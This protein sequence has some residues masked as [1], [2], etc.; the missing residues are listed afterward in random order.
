MTQHWKPSRLALA[1]PRSA[2]W[3]LHLEGEDVVIHLGDAIHRH[4]LGFDAR[5]SVKRGLLW[6]RVVVQRRDGPTITLDGLSHTDAST[7]ATAL[8]AA[9][10]AQDRRERGPAFLHTL[11]LMRQWNGEAEELLTERRA[12]RRWIG[13]DD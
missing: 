9:E 10:Q 6:A 4:T 13:H 11:G 7:L 1:L 5:L 12:H 3:E 2:A 8:D